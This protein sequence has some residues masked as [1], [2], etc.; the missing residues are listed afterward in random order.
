MIKFQKSCPGIQ[1][2]LNL[3]KGNL[4]QVIVCQMC[5]YYIALYIY[6]C[7]CV[8]LYTLHMFFW[9]YYIPY[10][11]CSMVLEYLPTFAQTK[12]PSH[13]GIPYMEHMGIGIQSGVS[14]YDG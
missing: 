1:L 5:M 8:C 12:S 7:V 4:W 6:A 11:I 10:A 13:V 3:F 2:L 14:W 9:T